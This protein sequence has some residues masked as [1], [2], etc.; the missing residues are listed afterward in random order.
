MKLISTMLAGCALMLGAC[1]ANAQEY[2]TH[3]SYSVLADQKNKAC[4]LTT[5]DANSSI[6]VIAYDAK[7]QSTTLGVANAAF[8]DLSGLEVPLFFLIDN[9][10]YQ[11]SGI[12]GAG[13][14]VATSTDKTVISRLINSQFFAMT[15]GETVIMAV[16]SEAS[17]EAAMKSTV[18]CATKVA[19]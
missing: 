12:G 7:T 13:S 4:G 2:S 1:E 15:V 9:D 11:W 6:V 8:G 18:A 3:G 5:V 14:I 16:E 19:K 10:V 17:F